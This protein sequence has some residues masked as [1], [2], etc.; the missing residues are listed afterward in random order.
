MSAQ[1][2]SYPIEVS[3]ETDGSGGAP[4]LSPREAVGRWINKLRASKSESTVSSYHYQL[5]LFVEYCEEHS[6]AS[7][8]EV[9]GWDIE[10][11]DTH[12][13]QQGVKIISLNKELITLRKF[14]QYCE[15]IE[16]VEEGVSEKVVPPD[17]PKPERVDETRLTVERARE[18]FEY[19]E[20]RQYGSRMHTV[21]TIFWY[22]GCRLSGLRGLNLDNYN[23]EEQYLEF[24]HK[25]NE[26]RSL[27]NGIDGQRAVGLPRDVCDIIDH[28]IEKERLDTYDD[29]GARPLITTQT[30]RPSRSAVRGWT[31]S[32]TFPCLHQSCPHGE[33]PAE[34][35]Y[36][37]YT[38]ASKC[39]SSRS[40]HQIRTGA[41]TWMLNRG[42]PIEVVAKN[43]NT[44]VR[45][46][47]A[48]YDQ[49]TLTEDLENRRRQ[50]V[51]RLQFGSTEA[52]L[53]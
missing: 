11:Y 4:E 38:H 49:P 39:P 36:R 2:A 13:R 25:P 31:Y 41:I 37:D 14:L 21:L 53:Q 20:S 45:I 3:A 8:R 12:R 40:P 6:I 27:K 17:V 18:L 26:G 44:S 24:L 50:H 47:K 9:D 52:D 23:S 29:L 16:I 1:N 32:S 5:K 35:E 19:H 43:V 46:L 28:Y 34:C 7:I 10:S 42:V 15:R 22:T 48:H 30:G 33:D 51:E